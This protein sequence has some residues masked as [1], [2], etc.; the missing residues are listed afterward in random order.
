TEFDY[1]T[2]EV[3]TGV[4]SSQQTIIAVPLQ[5]IIDDLF[6]VEAPDQRRKLLKFRLEFAELVGQETTLLSRT[7]ETVAKLEKQY[8]L[9]PAK[10]G[11]PAAGKP[12]T[13]VPAR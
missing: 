4:Y 13:A 1:E 12:P 7:A 5:K 2:V 11:R 6:D 3:L 8:N 9:Q 10:G